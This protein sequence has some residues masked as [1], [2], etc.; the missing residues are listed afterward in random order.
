MSTQERG[1]FFSEIPAPAKRRMR[2]DDFASKMRE[3]PTLWCV[4]GKYEN[5]KSGHRIGVR[6]R[7]LYPDC[8]FSTRWIA[9]EGVTVIY[10]RYMPTTPDGSGK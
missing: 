9:D 7:H 6:L 2:S 1:E 4:I 8:E 5:R 3:N 10:G